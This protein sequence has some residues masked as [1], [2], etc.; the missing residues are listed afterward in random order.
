MMVPRA[1]TAKGR[2]L[3]V[4]V[5]DDQE[6]VRSFLRKFFSGMRLE[7]SV[8]ENGFQAIE[9]VKKKRFDLYLIDVRMP[10]LNG[11]ETLRG[12]RRIDPSAPAVIMTG[13]ADQD[14]LEGIRAE[15]VVDILAKPFD[16]RRLREVVKTVLRI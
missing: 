12:I 8:A 6:G 16:L 3:I 14:I 5:I 11:L 4:L 10:G 7:V 2:A 9:S 13:Y 1:E 15:G